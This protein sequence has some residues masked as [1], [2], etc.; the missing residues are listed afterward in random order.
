M[1]FWKTWLR[2]GS[3]VMT[4]KNERGD[5]NYLFIYMILQMLNSVFKGAFGPKI[6]LETSCSHVQQT[7]VRVGAE[8][9]L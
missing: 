8:A 4:L 6:P 9:A 3:R 7:G 5:T 2:S 1:L